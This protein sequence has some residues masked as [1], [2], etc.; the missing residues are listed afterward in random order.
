MRNILI[1]LGSLVLGGALLVPVAAHAWPFGLPNFSPLVDSV[2]PSVVFIQTM[3]KSR[4]PTLM[5]LLEPPKDTVPE[6]IEDY[7]PR[8]VGSGFILKSDGLVMT[9]A[10]VVAGAD[11]IFV[12]LTDE[13]EF[14]ATVIG[15]DTHTD[16]A[17]LKIEATN[18]PAVRI[19][20][21]SRLK[22]GDWI[23]AIGAPYGFTHTVTAGVVS[24]ARR[25][26][27]EDVIFIQHD[28]AINPGN[29]GGPLFNMR[30]EVV[31]I[32]SQIYSR[33]G[34][35]QGISFAIPIDEAMRVAALLLDTGR[36]ARGSIGLY[37]DQVSKKIAE[38]IGLTKASGA[39]VRG[40]M[41]GAPAALA[42]VEVG[43]VVL[44][45]GAA[46]IKKST[47][48]PRAVSK[49]KPGS[50]STITVLRHGAIIV[51]SITVGELEEAKS[52]ELNITEKGAK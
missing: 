42:G 12:T 18:L 19:G 1:K 27:G 16:V 21:M 39:L 2:G 24:K 45:F 25:D 28:A 34:G 9:N 33:S 8:G 20:D 4:P 7:L 3:E 26:I 46:D 32:N 44:K 17:L 14:E 23:M 51:L 43:D 30:G 6:K 49:T 5:G 40:V 48:L 35:F 38:S 50:K 15:I 31:G 52:P 37:V 10:H 36:V 41:I 22:D 11:K 47:D 13:R 29:S